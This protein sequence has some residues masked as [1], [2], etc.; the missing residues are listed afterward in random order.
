[1]SWY[2]E[3][4]GVF[5][6]VEKTTAAQNLSIKAIPALPNLWLNTP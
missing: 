2:L 6:N 4:T 1:M 3:H 5:V